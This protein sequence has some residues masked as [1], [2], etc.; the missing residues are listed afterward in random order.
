[1]TSQRS[2]GSS[3]SVEEEEEAEDVTE[4]QMMSQHVTGGGSMSHPA[5][6][7]TENTATSQMSLGQTVQGIVTGKQLLQ[8]RLKK[9]TFGG[10]SKKS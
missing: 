9:D 7:V 4:Q 2:G 10:K 1:M 6:I 3:V 5:R 8:K